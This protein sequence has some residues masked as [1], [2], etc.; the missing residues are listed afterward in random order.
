MRTELADRLPPGARQVEAMARGHLFFGW[1]RGAAALAV[2]HSV[3]GDGPALCS[4]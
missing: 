4:A 1:A 2:Q 3:R